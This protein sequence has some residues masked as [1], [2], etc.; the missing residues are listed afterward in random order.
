VGP[1]KTDGLL[2]TSINLFSESLFKIIFE[3]FAI[4][5]KKYYSSPNKKIISY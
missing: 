2:Q 5:P 4:L 1:T 3:K